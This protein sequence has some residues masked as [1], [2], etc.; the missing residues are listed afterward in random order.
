MDKA[1]GRVHY[2]I[3]CMLSFHNGRTTSFVYVVPPKSSD[4]LAIK[5]YGK[6]KKKATRENKECH[7][8][9]MCIKRQYS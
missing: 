6:T 3:R 8:N 5:F 4:K 1:V 2:L 7:L 9:E